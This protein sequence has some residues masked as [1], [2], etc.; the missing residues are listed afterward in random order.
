MTEESQL[1]YLYCVAGKEPKL[2]QIEA[3]ESGVYSICHN[4][5]YAVAAK[6]ERRQFDAEGLKKNMAD[7]KWFSYMVGTHERIIER[8]ATETG[9]IPFRFGTLFST[10]NSLKAMLEQYGQQFEAILNRLADKQE[11]GLKIYC[12]QVKL[13]VGLSDDLTKILTMDDEI[14]RSSV[15]KA[16][17]LKKKKEAIVQ[18]ALNEKINECGRKSFESLRDL[19]CE[20]RVTKLLPKEVTERKDDMVLNA[21]F[22]V[23]KAGTDDFLNMTRTLKTHYEGNGFLID[24]T[25][26]WPPYNFCSLPRAQRGEVKWTV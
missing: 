3:L 19:S 8:I 12:D 11:W 18:E 4:C 10:D 5:L 20:A 15:G 25:G 16:Y 14:K 23:D 21:A 26:P 1:T 2:E 22:L 9:V 17:F 24:C 6:V 7:L 13:K